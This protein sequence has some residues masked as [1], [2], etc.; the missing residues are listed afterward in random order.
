VATKS[1]LVLSRITNAS[2]KQL[3]EY[4]ADPSCTQE[5]RRDTVGFLEQTKLAV[6]SMVSSK[7]S[8]LNEIPYKF[9][10]IISHLMGGRSIE[11]SRAVCVECLLERDR[12]LATCPHK[13][14]RVAVFLATGHDNKSRIDLEVFARGGPLG[15]H[16][17]A[18][19]R[20][21]AM[22]S[23]ALGNTRT[24]QL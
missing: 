8:Y 3:T 21:Y 2:S 23:L 7:L 13:L 6:C 20:K 10:G 19:L 9:L 11:F 12:I 18:E 17:V 4:L 16:A 1:D 15:V 24:L 5:I 22:A 14:H